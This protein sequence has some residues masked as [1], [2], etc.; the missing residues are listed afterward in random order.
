MT[1]EEIRN[2]DVMSLKDS[3]SGACFH[4]EVWVRCPHCGKATEISYYPNVKDGYFIIKCECGKL[5]RDKK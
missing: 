4:G 3:L 5:Y 2:I 1:E